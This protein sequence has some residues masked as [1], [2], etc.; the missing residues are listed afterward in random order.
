MSE[1]DYQGVA[2]P[3]KRVRRAP[4]A[5]IVRTR[6]VK[7]IGRQRSQHWCERCGLKR[8]DCKCPPEARS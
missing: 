5:P 4:G 7:S 1:S 6:P 8:K 2:A 3:I